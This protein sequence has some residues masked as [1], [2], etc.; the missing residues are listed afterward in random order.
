MQS[1]DGL[2]SREQMKKKEKKL[3][4]STQQKACNSSSIPEGQQ[5]SPKW[6]D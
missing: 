5:G 6:L 4:L 3:Y 1:Q 2:V